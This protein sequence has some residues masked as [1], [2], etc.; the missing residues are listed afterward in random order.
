MDKWDD[1]A[2][3]AVELEVDVGEEE[4][5]VGFD[6]VLD[7]EFDAFDDDDAVKEL[8]LELE[9]ELEAVTDVREDVRE[10]AREVV[11]DEEGIAV[12]DEL[13]VEVRE[14]GV[15]EPRNVQTSSGPRGIC[16]FSFAQAL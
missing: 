3:G 8:E 16:K 9:L 5:D 12:D 10:V 7:G 6:V 11:A 14:A 4:V 1:A 2:T 13:W 15:V